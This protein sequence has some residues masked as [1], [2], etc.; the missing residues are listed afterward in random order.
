LLCDPTRTTLPPVVEKAIR[1]RATQIEASTADSATRT[2]EAVQRAIDQLDF[3]GAA[4]RLFARAKCGELCP[5]ELVAPILPRMPNAGAAALLVLLADGDRGG[6]VAALLETDAFP[7][8]D[9][10]LLCA[11]ACAIAALA[12][13]AEL[14]HP[15][16]ALEAR[17]LAHAIGTDAP[18]GLYFALNALAHAL[19]D[20]GLARQLP[21][22]SGPAPATVIAIETMSRM[23]REHLLAAIDYY[24]SEDT[25]QGRA[26]AVAERTELGRNEPC[27]C[28]SG[29]KFKRCHGAADA[30]ARAVRPARSLTHDDVQQMLLAEL[31]EVR[32]TQLGDE[33]LAA[34]VHRL[35][36]Y[37]IFDVAERALAAL[38]TRDHLSREARDGA[39]IAFAVQAVRGRRLALASKHFGLVRSQRYAAIK[40]AM[41]LTLAITQ[42]APDAVERLI[43]FSERAVRDPSGLLLSNL[44]EALCPL[45]PAL[46][47]IFLRAAV[48]SDVVEGRRDQTFHV[49]GEARV[50]LKLDPD[51]P[52]QAMYMAWKQAKAERVDRQEL[53]R[54]LAES[55][56]EVERLRGSV[57]EANRRAR[58]AER[59][60]DGLEQRLREQAA[61]RPAADVAAE[62]AEI[63]ALREK[64]DGLHA[65]IREKNAELAELRRRPATPG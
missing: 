19:H 58:E 12:S 11:I 48:A 15:R 30:P 27:W 18:R 60:A 38:V 55:N 50:R 5:I 20:D 34:A 43:T 37:R 39:R 4:A 16:L 62:P 44:G 59:R 47:L 25:A 7:D 51:E 2:V 46:G 6:T 32:F 14:A 65:T 17:I 52:S 45:V 1:L 33:T 3:I 61:V 26:V 13:G 22:T 35:L 8:D 64:I 21:R 29:K 36:K 40:D 56:A 28:A 24:F 54:R 49:A 57:T 41:T 31:A 10:G 23:S 53:E 9:I 42:R 63:R